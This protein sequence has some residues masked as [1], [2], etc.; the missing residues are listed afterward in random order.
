MHHDAR[1]KDKDSLMRKYI[2]PEVLRGLE[3]GNIIG[4]SDPGATAADVYSLGMVFKDIKKHISEFSN[5]L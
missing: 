5:F 2:A 4:P 1:F 3:D